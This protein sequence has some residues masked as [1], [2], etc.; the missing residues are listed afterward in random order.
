VSG[1]RPTLPSYLHEWAGRHPES[2]PA[3]SA[4]LTAVAS[5]ATLISDRLD[6]GALADVLGSAG[7]QNVQ[8]E[9]QKNL[10]VISNDLMVQELLRCGQSAALASEEVDELIPVPPGVRRGDHL[11]CFD[12]LDGSSNIDVNLTVGTIFS[13][14]RSPRPGT[15]AETA[16][17]LQPGT[18]QVAAGF[19]L[20]GPSTLLVLTTGE[21]V[22]AFTLDRDT[23]QFVLTHPQLR[24]PREAD[25]FAINTS[26]ERFWEAPVQRYV[27]ECLAG[28]AGPR[29]RDVNMRWV[30]SLV[31]DTF[32]ILTR[33]GAYLYP[34]DSR[35]PT[36]PGRLRL[37]YECNPIA[38]VIEQAGGMATTGRQRILEVEVTG[39]H[40]RIPFIFGSAAEV[41][42]IERLHR[43]HDRD[44]PTFDASLFNTRSLFRAG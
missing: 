24:I 42:R 20:Y 13:I 29:G 14:L 39:L 22:D 26:N 21:G 3:I 1:P 38:F 23:G 36:R 5:A 12:P 6:R 17:F 15:A 43:E 40:Q 30:A 2:G 31:A 28:T 7:M 25:E 41:E 18:A 9:V 35:R 19:A 32:R 44:D 27:S 33:G 11:V 37:T 16:D 4:L 10:D 8:G 34:L